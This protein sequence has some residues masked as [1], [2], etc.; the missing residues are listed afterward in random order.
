MTIAVPKIKKPKKQP[1]KKTLERKADRLWSKLVCRKGYCEWC[2]KSDG[3]LDAHHIMGRARKNLR[4]D[5]RN[6]VCLCFRCHRIKC[7]GTDPELAQEYLNWIKEYKADDWQYLTDKK[8]RTESGC[9]NIIKLQ[10]YLNTMEEVED[11]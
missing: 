2:G 7:H 8:N 3:K 11:V 4:W 9:F 6:G 1:S 5:L 10:E